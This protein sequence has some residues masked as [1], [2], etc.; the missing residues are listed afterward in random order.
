MF[1][2][3]NKL[4]DFITTLLPSYILVAPYERAVLHRAEKSKELGPGFHVYWPLISRYDILPVNR[5]FIQTPYQILRTRDGKVVAAS[6]MIV[7]TVR[8]PRLAICAV[9]SLEESLA[10]AG[11]KAVK[12]VVTGSDFCDLSAADERIMAGVKESTHGW[13]LALREAYLKD[14]VPCRAYRIIGETPT[15]EE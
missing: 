6:A 9:Y 15:A 5:Q 7:F 14:F 2:W 4:F 11:C 10:D 1:D 12:D 13:G 8:D 3:L